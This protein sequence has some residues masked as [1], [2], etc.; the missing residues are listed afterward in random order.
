MPLL[1][2]NRIAFSDDL[3]LLA[4][5]RGDIESEASSDSLVGTYSFLY[6]SE[7]WHTPATALDIGCRTAIL[8]TPARLPVH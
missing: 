5:Q 7:Q 2:A 1:A 8:P 3:A 4:A 6:R